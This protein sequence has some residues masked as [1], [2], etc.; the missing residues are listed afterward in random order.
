[1]ARLTPCFSA[2]RTVR[3]YAEEHYLPAAA[4]CRAR[5]APV[6][7]RMGPSA[8]K[9]SI[10]SIVRRLSLIAA[11]RRHEIRVEGAMGAEGCPLGH[12]GQVPLVVQFAFPQTVASWAS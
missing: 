8:G 6:P 11:A 12:V 9:S 4:A 2:S 5:A 10:G 1:M 3:E 7:R